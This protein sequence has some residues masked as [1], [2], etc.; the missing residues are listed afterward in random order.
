M[1]ALD[2]NDRYHWH[3]DAGGFHNYD[4]ADGEKLNKLPASSWYCQ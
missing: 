1:R 2:N 3:C 4:D